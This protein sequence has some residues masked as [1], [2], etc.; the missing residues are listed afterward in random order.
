MTNSFLFEA[1]ARPVKNYIL[2]IFLSSQKKNCS[3]MAREVNI[4][5]KQLYEVYKNT[6]SNAKQI[7]SLLLKKAINQQKK[8]NHHKKALPSVLILDGVIIRKW[9]AKSMEQL[10]CDYDGVINKSKK[11]LSPIVAAWTNSKIT[12]P[13][14][15]KFWVNEKIAKIY[16]KKT[17][18]AQELILELRKLIQFDYVALDGAFASQGFMDFCLRN[19]IHFCMRIAK[20]R[21]IIS[22]SGIKAQLQN[23]PELKF[24]GN[25]C[26]KTIK[27]TYKGLPCFFTA[28]KRYTKNRKSFQIVFIVSSLNVPAK[29]QAILYGIRW[30]IEKMF[31]T[32]KQSLGLSDCQCLSEKKQT[33]HIFSVFL[34]YAKLEE[35]KVYKRKKS[36]EVVLKK[37]RPPKI[38][39]RTRMK[40]LERRKSYV[41][42]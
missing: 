23:H 21:V 37:M 5:R 16:K 33:I 1:I 6:E 36:P 31:R 14:D 32:T 12:I 3:A 35:K 30:N 24:R 20:N 40:P 25:Q 7:K 19:L 17:E 38:P 2:A 34:A 10:A 11:C 41:E 18:I 28:H 22:E 13:L 26:Y 4:P 42:A 9:F 8:I 15:F 39:D 29:E 27:G